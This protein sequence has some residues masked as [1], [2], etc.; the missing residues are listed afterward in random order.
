MY[1]AESA[2]LPPSRTCHPLKAGVAC[3]QQ[4]KTWVRCSGDAAPPPGKWQCG[5]TYTGKNTDVLT[6]ASSRDECYYMALKK[7]PGGG[8]KGTAGFTY[9]SYNPQYG[10]VGGCFVKAA[11][12]GAKR[13][14]HP[15]PAHCS[16][17]LSP[18]QGG[19]MRGIRR[20]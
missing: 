17:R 1:T 16:D 15:T 18:L 13:A 8:S 5:G 9:L 20:Q 10:G 14:P 4:D 12:S 6:P 11:G 2:S 3:N 7:Y 19:S